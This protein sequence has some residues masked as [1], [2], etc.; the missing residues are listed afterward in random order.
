MK[1]LKTLTAIALALTYV[2]AP[3]ALLAGDKKEEKAKGE[4]K[5]AKPA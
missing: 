1:K 2:T 4:K 3:M 5:A